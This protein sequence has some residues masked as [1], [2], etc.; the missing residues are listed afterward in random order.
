MLRPMHRGLFGDHKVAVPVLVGPGRGH[1]FHAY[2]PRSGL[3]LMMGRYEPT[4][5]AFVRDAVRD[6]DTFIDVGAHRGFFTRVAL[7]AMPPHGQ[8]VA[9][10]PDSRCAEPLR[11]IDPARVTVRGEALGRA[12]GTANLISDEHNCGQLEGA[13]PTQMDGTVTPVEVRDLDGLIVAG[14]VPRPDVMK[15]DVEGAELDV[16]A[17]ASDAVKGL[18]A[19]VVECHSM[20][21]LRDVLAV[22]LES[23]DWVRVTE[24]GDFLGPPAVLARRS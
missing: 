17:G 5:A 14:E 9:F 7:R 10:E 21:L 6:A 3:R 1:R 4:V 8:V 24:G 16:L 13:A 19:I 23:F 18:S 2:G 12:R 22:L 11:A 15:V 20:P